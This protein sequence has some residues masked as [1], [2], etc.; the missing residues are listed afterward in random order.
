MKNYKLTI[1]VTLTAKQELTQHQIDSILEHN[2]DD[3]LVE[4]CDEY[5]LE[6][7]E[8]IMEITEV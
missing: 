3:F 8:E 5:S 4:L 7:Q 6:P 1:E 2:C